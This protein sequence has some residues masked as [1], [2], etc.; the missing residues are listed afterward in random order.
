MARLGITGV[1]VS[2]EVGVGSKSGS[3]VTIETGDGPGEEAV[4]RM[5]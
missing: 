4:T 2:G 3:G 1:G 5:D